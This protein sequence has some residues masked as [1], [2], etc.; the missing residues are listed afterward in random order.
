MDKSKN[1]KRETPHP[2]PDIVDKPSK[3]WHDINFKVKLEFRKEFKQ[4]AARHNMTMVQLL[5]DCYRV[6]V[7]IYD[8]SMP[9]MPTPL[10]SDD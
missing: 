2:R 9:T 7:A 8:S 3:K 5:Y 6:W 4:R 10:P 1:D